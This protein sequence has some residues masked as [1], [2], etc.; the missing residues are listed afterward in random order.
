MP[1][2]FSVTIG[3]KQIVAYRNIR[4]DQLAPGDLYI[5]KRN[6]GWHL[7]KCLYVNREDGWVMPDP[8]AS[9]YSYDCHECAKVKE[10]NIIGGCGATVYAADGYVCPHLSRQQVFSKAFGKTS[11]CVEEI[12]PETGRCLHAIIELNLEI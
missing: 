1:D 11:P 10:I 8:P 5:A 3:R 2:T 6:T 4:G 7:A 12:Q 9:I